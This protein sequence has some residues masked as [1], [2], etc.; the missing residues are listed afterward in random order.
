MFCKGFDVGL[1][2]CWKVCLLG[3]PGSSHLTLLW[4]TEREKANEE[5]EGWERERGRESNNHHPATSSHSASAGAS[6]NTHR[7]CFPRRPL[8][9]NQ[10]TTP[11]VQSSPNVSDPS[12]SPAPSHLHCNWLALKPAHTLRTARFYWVTGA[13]RGHI[14]FGRAHWLSA[15]P[16]PHNNLHLAEMCLDIMSAC[17]GQGIFSLFF[18]Y[19]SDKSCYWVLLH[20]HFSLITWKITYLRWNV[21]L[22]GFV[23]EFKQN[24]WYLFTLCIQWSAEVLLL[25]RLI[26]MQMKHISQ[27]L[28]HAGAQ[29][30]EEEEGRGGA[31]CQQFRGPG[32][33]MLERKGSATEINEVQFSEEHQSHWCR[34]QAATQ[35]GPLK[36]TT[37]PKMQRVVK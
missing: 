15:L 9:A 20:S 21:L 27:F 29:R 28:P 23:W 18:L 13:K 16:Q 34:P 37:T 12:D 5:E 14:L 36:Q 4:L 22:K 17:L 2:N 6:I 10:S 25:A 32:G 19:S 30:R 7:K 24:N 26:N 1:E 11:L 3:K 33:P 35:T 8:W 31:R